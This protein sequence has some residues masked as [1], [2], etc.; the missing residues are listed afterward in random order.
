MCR[1]FF[2]DKMRD[3]CSAIACSTV[4]VKARTYF[5]TLFNNFPWPFYKIQNLK[6]YFEN[7]TKI[8]GS[9]ICLQELT[10]KILL[11]SPGNLTFCDQLQTQLSHFS[12]PGF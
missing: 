12:G 5:S 3:L 1:R 6:Y 9:W 2:P 10:N 7:V 11:G 4:F 8:N